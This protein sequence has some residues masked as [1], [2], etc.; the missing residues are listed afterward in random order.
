MKIY[1]YYEDINFTKQKRLIELWKASWEYHGFTPIVL[2]RENATQHAYYNEY[3]SGLNT[4]NQKL[5]GKDMNKYCTSCFLR[6]LAYTSISDESMLVSDYDVINGGVDASEFSNYTNEQINLLQGVCPSLVIGTSK[7]FIKLCHMFINMSLSHIDEIK[8]GSSLINLNL[9]HDQVFF[10][11]LKDKLSINF[12]NN[13]ELIHGSAHATSSNRKNRLIHFSHQYTKMRNSIP[14][15]M[16][17]DVTMQDLE[18]MR[19]DLIEEFLRSLSIV[20]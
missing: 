15:V 13:T 6:W 12:S 16:P 5:Y 19:V 18:R 10:I 3:I 14:I 4:I 9:F 7:Q 2:T 8:K 17:S 1:T 11:F 20:S